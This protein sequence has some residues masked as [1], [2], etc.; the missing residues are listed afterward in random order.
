MCCFYT[1]IFQKGQMNKKLTQSLRK[2]TANSWQL[3]FSFEWK[4]PKDSQKHRYA[5]S[6]FL[7]RAWAVPSMH[8]L[9]H[10]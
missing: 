10:S 6:K 2:S 4:K 7:S 1:G 8:T 9:K 5:K 3:M